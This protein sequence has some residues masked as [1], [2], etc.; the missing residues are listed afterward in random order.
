[1][2]FDVEIW[3]DDA[4]PPVAR[5]RALQKPRTWCATTSRRSLARSVPIS[6][7]NDEQVKIPANG[8]SLAGTLVEA[9]K[10]RRQTVAGGRS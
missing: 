8:F 9:R 4:G 10:R 5:E 7:P 2:P 1:M 3:A 6:R